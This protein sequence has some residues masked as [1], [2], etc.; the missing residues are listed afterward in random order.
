M[1]ETSATAALDRLASD[2]G[3]DVI[4]LDLLMP[5]LTGMEFHERVRERFP[6]LTERI[7][8]VTGGA[9]TPDG[10]TFLESVPNARLDKP[11]DPEHVRAIVQHT[12]AA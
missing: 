2:R 10:V 7:V 11:F 9:F 8:V 12:A 4:F 6:S 5:E 3:F 1:V